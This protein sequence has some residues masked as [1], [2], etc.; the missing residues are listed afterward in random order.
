MPSRTSLAS[1]SASAD[2][3]GRTLGVVQSAGSLGRVIG[4]I[5]A[6]ALLGAQGSLP[7][8]A[9]PIASAAVIVLAALL[10]VR[11]S[12]ATNS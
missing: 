3:Q 2:W 4:P 9:L 12:S 10:M 7:Y 1:R 5:A 11:G 8:G 6:G